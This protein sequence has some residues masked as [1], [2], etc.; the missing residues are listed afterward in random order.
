MF[1][2]LN[3]RLINLISISLSTVGVIIGIEAISIPGLRST[4]ARSIKKED[5]GTVNHK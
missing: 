3:D 2:E 5:L 1:Q 4:V